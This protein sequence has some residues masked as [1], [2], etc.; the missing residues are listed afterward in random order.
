MLEDL[1]KPGH[2]VDQA[3]LARHGLALADIAG[4]VSTHSLDAPIGTLEA[5]EGDIIVRMRLPG[6]GG[7]GAVVGAVAASRGTD[8]VSLAPMR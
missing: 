3:A 4:A 5:R 8:Y 1:G 7:A 6:T 2:G